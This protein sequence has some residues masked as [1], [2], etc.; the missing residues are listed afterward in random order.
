MVPDHLLLGASV[1]STMIMVT[2]CG[3][4][5]KYRKLHLACGI[6]LVKNE[7]WRLHNFT[8][9]VNKL[10][11]IMCVPVWGVWGRVVSTALCWLGRELFWDR[12]LTFWGWAALDFYQLVACECLS[13]H[14]HAGK[15]WA[16]LFEPKPW[17]MIRPQFILSML[18]LCL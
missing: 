11:L 16:D 1:S 3:K 5:R 14:L 4:V 7:F 15:T 8:F 9:Y 12:G 6:L 17:R 10:S 18:I 13:K 2:N